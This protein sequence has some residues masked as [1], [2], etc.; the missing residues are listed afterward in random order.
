MNVAS[1]RPQA[2]KRQKPGR[3]TRRAEEPDEPAPARTDH[4][5]WPRDWASTESTT[6]FPLPDRTSV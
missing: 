6:Q 2:E 3:E 4:L 5:T 1:Q